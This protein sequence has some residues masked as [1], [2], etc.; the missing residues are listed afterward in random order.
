ML[1]EIGTMPLPQPG[2]REFERMI[3]TSH[4]KAK[5]RQPAPDEVIDPQV[6]EERR[7]A[8]AFLSEHNRMLRHI[9]CRTQ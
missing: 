7:L 4:Q 3:H 5:R 8:D 6:A 1:L 9:D 2:T